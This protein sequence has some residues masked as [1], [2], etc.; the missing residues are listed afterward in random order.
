MSTVLTSL[1]EWDRFVFQV[2]NRGLSNPVFDLLLPYVRERSVWI[3]LYLYLFY[4]VITRFSRKAAVAMV[5]GLALSAGAA[6]FTS[7][8]LIKKNVQRLRPCNEPA[9]KEQVVLRLEHCGSGYSFTSSHASNHFAVAVYVI[10]WLGFLGAWVRPAFLLWAISIA[11][12]Q[13][14]VGVH[15]PLDV[16]MG[17]LLGAGFGWLGQKVSRTFVATNK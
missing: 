13:V 8:N 3:P 10:G 12:A 1:L 11:F 17:G 16:L 15:Y 6:D 9:L 5:L 7:S 14:Y 2:V 4:V